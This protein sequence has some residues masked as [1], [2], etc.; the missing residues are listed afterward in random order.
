MAKVNLLIYKSWMDLVFACGVYS[1]YVKTHYLRNT[2][3]LP[4]QSLNVRDYIRFKGLPGT[5][6]G[7][8]TSRPSWGSKKLIRQKSCSRE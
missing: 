3:V 5:F 1:C 8:L 4:K 7:G 2:R 6:C